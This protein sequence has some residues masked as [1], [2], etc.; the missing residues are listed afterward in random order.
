[1]SHEEVVKVEMM[2]QEAGDL[3]EDLGLK[4]KE[5]PEEWRTVEMEVALLED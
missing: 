4:V 1:V 5:G 3:F 2:R